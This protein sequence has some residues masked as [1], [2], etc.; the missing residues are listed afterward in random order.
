MTK[1]YEIRA[2]SALLALTAVII[3]AAG[4]AKKSGE[5]S[6]TSA[7]ETASET[8]DQ[9]T[10]REPLSSI[11]IDLNT[12]KPTTDAET[13]ASAEPDGTR[14]PQSLDMGSSYL[15]KFTFISDF[16]VCG[17]RS[18]GMLPEGQKTDR[19]V[20]GLGGSLYVAS[21]EPLLY[22]PEYGGLL[23]VTDYAARRR[24]EYLLIA[25]GAS[26][27][28]AKNAPSETAF[29]AS[30]TTLLTNIK[31]ASP[32]T[33]IVCLSILPGSP[34]SGISIYDVEKYNSLILSAAKATGTYYL[35]AAS[36]FAGSDGYLRTDCDGGSS[37]LSTT[38]LRKLLDLIR[39]HYAA[40]IEADVSDQS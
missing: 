36:A 6:S 9:T 38:G 17:L 22:A 3:A 27:I 20:S 35:D 33:V 15:D 19:V 40:P 8:T 7:S 31:E 5:P 14:L 16:S 24:P 39:T 28:S 4:C 37:R 18:L 32:D 26:D 30:Y 2:V 1:K 23:T 25:L 13:D 11:V 10:T 29:S 34:S 21:D 12:E